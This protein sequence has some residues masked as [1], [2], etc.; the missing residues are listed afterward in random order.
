MCQALFGHFEYTREQNKDLWNLFTM[1]KRIYILS[2]HCTLYISYNFTCQLYLNKAGGAETN[3]N[4]CP[5]GPHISPIFAKLLDH[6]R[7]SLPVI[8][9]LQQLQASCLHRM[10]YKAGRKGRCKKPFTS[11]TFFFMGKKIF[12]R[13]PYHR[14]PFTYHRPKLGLLRMNMWLGPITDKDEWDFLTVS[15]QEKT[16]VTTT[17]SSPASGPFLCRP[18]CNYRRATPTLRPLPPLLH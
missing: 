5:N 11:W 4:L 7:F 2:L 15:N 1:C 8:R 12:P 16:P 10:A 13:N 17:T 6:C 3:T 9:C 18:S 14:L